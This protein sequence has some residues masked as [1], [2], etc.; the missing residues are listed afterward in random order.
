MLEQYR[1]PFYTSL[2][3][4][5]LSKFKNAFRFVVWLVVSGEMAKLYLIY[6]KYLNHNKTHIIKA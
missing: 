6:I 2:K 4:F 3:I 5:D 1:I